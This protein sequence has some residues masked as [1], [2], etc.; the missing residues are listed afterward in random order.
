MNRIVSLSF[1]FALVATLISAATPVAAGH[2]APVASCPALNAIDPDSD[3]RMTAGE[4]VKR[5]V[6]V[7]KAINDDG[8]RTLEADETYTRLSPEAFASADRNKDGR[9]HMG[10]WVRR[11][12]ILFRN[13]NPDR[14]GTIECDELSVGWGRGLHRMLR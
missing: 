5:G 8:D 9:L 7:F 11:I 4:A 14:D 1:V 2:R 3:G 6:H 13:A 12:V 10:E